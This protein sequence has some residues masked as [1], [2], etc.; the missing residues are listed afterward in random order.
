MI[1]PMGNQPDTSRIIIG[2]VTLDLKQTH[3]ENL[4]YLVL[5]PSAS[6]YYVL[7]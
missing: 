6:F 2:H 7:L 3:F 4:N 5:L 1:N